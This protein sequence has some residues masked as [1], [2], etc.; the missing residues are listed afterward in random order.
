MSFGIT[1]RTYNVG[2]SDY[3]K[4]KYQCWDI[5]KDFELDPLRADMVKRLLRRKDGEAR[6]TDLRKIKHIIEEVKEQF[7]KKHEFLQKQFEVIRNEYELTQGEQHLLYLI[8]W[9]N[10][11]DQTATVFSMEKQIE[12]ILKLEER[13]KEVSKE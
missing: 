4:H 13:K 1:H 5:W 8:L 7:K 10:I 9:A 2:E 11:D 6:I 3:S 12:R